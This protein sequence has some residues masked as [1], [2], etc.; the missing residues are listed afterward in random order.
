[1]FQ[2][3]FM[4]AVAGDPVLEDFAQHVV[5]E[6]SARFALKAAKGGA[7][8]HERV[9]DGFSGTDRYQRDQTLR[10]HL[11]NGMLPAL[12]I[13]RYLA[14]WG[15]LALE[16]WDEQHER[17]FITGYMLH[18]FTKIESV[19]ARL[20]KDFKPGEAP[21][22]TQVP[23]LEEI[24]REW[25]E[26]LG[27]EAFLQP[28]GGAEPYLHDLIYI[29]CNTQRLKG[30]F[31]L[32]AA[33]ARK[34]LD[35]DMRDTLTELSR[36]ADLIAYVAPTPRDVV[37]HDGIRKII[38]QHLAFD[39]S[40]LP[41][42]RLTYH[43]VAENRGLLL[44][45]IHNAAI[46][47]M[48]VDDARVPLLYTPSG[49]VYLERR[50]AP[51]V[52][53]VDE[54]AAHIADTIR[55]KAGDKLLSSGKGAK[56]G[57][58][59][60][61]IDD[62]YNDFFSLPEMV[63]NSMKLVTRYIRSNK[64]PSRFEKMETHQWTGWDNIPLATPT[65]SKDAR[66]DQ[67][68]EWAGFVETQFRDRFDKDTTDIV[69]WLL[70]HLGIRDLADDFF[71]LKGEATR[72]GLRYWWHWGA[73]HA[74]ARQGAMD[75]VAV[76]EWLYDL[77]LKLVEEMP[78][79]LPEKA[80]VNPQT[81]RDMKDYIRRVLTVRG[82]KSATIAK[83]TELEQYIHAKTR[84][85][86]AVCAIC[87]MEYATRQPSETAV[88][89]QP[90]V[91]TQRLN[92]GASNNK[93]RLCS[94]CATEQLLRQL[95]MN[96]LDSGSRAE[97][98]RIRYL[99]FY[100]SYFFSPETLRIVQK[101]YTALKALRLSDSDLRRAL[102]Q[103]SDLQDVTF[104]QGLDVFFLRPDGESNESKFQRVL[105]YADDA[106]S[107]YFTAG[108]RNID[109]TETE[110]WV[111]PAFLALVMSVCL[112]VK[113][114]ASDSGIPLLLEAAELPETV[115]FDGAHAAVQ[116]IIQH[117]RLHIDNIGAALARLTATY[118]IHL[119]TEYAP[120]KE[121]WQRFTPIAN[122]L[123]ESPLYVFHY[124]KKQE[125]DGK[126]ITQNQVRRYV[127]YAE[128]FT[129]QGDKDMSHARELVTG[130]R[131]FYRAK[132]FKNANSILRPLSVVS[133]ALLVADQRLFN[134]VDSLTEVAHGELY[135]FMDRVGKGLA[136][137]RFPKGITVEARQQAMRDFSA[138]FVTEIFM[139]AF[140][141]DVSALRG[142]Q[143]NLLKSACEVIY[144]DLQ[145]DEW[146]DRD[147]DPDEVDTSE[148]I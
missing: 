97:G 146:A 52:L 36:L 46:D 72:G 34:I 20:E 15:S 138:Y 2:T 143:L 55:Q 105:T 122:A 102:K 31:R 47:A 95:F 50:D 67:I 113:V 53:S 38:S 12:R 101:A 147:P 68:A 23:L 60:L 9:A 62:S 22:E 103:Q 81:W 44:N 136:D 57:N 114:V 10:A 92:I 42:G 100:P 93:R 56:R 70:E 141:G 3:L 107:T 6:L 73:A 51:P 132:N 104:W 35:V 37:A 77:S 79:A 78:E 48:T 110:S 86:Q 8:F 124:L 139:G 54:L 74:L 126:R 80:Q 128:L 96:H 29:A 64:T 121:N 18:D 117:D 30:T 61:Q 82:E 45:L 91:Y 14:W 120:P 134:D 144:R 119:D 71:I 76:Q 108:F 99:S 27:L 115:W 1:M 90:G 87:G 109:P 75:D 39:D 63:A 142:K 24:F 123:C 28:I 137:G 106:Q 127:Y 58:T 21:S 32:P 83:S 84:R 66:V 43:H 130:Y 89:F 5:G 88:A 17:L 135:R 40:G 129:Q 112:D 11:I 7:F 145:L 4:E 59:S 116:N 41:V 148:A 49:V 98:Q 140:N 16:D 13:A 33:L 133:D 111:V 19:K 25:C 94:I 65:D 85:G 125:R 118:L 69:N 26:K 131:G